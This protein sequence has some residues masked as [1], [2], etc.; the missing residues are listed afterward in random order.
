[1]PFAN[2]RC[3]LLLC[4]LIGLIITILE[5]NRYFIIVALF[6]FSNTCSKVYLV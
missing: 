4:Y 5:P 2:Q 3:H 6:Q 1:M